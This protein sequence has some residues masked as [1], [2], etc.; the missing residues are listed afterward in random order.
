MTRDV[1]GLLCR[2]DL[3]ARVF[4]RK[5]LSFT[6]IAAYPTTTDR[7]FLAVDAIDESDLAFQA[8]AILE[9][10]LGKKLGIELVYA[11]GVSA[12]DYVHEDGWHG[13]LLRD[14]IAQIVDG[15]A[16]VT[17]IGDLGEKGHVSRLARANGT[18]FACGTHE[19]GIDGFIGKVDGKKFAMIAKCSDAYEPGN[20]K[21]LHVGTSGR[22]YVGGSW[23]AFFVGDASGFKPAD[24]PETAFATTPDDLTRRHELLSI[25]EKADGTV[26]IGCRDIGAIYA[27]NAVTKLGGVDRMHVRAVAEHGGIEY[28]AVDDRMRDVVGLYKRKDKKLSQSVAAKQKPI[29][30]RKLPDAGIRTVVAA[31]KM[32]VTNGDRIHLHDGAAWSQLKIQPDVAA[33]VKRVP[34]GMKAQ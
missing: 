11:T 29:W 3:L 20:F 14:G 17:P 33:L 16:T 22:V 23:G 34:A 6:T 12:A 2:V 8:S 9:I 26:M 10:T 4:D 21:A 13:L 1:R 30:H 24:L 19:G 28:W 27:N 31:G 5:G 15:T 18:V 7:L 32:A 25:F